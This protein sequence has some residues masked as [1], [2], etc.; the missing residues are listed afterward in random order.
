MIDTIQKKLPHIEQQHQ[1]TLLYVAE[2][3]SRAW[4]VASTD[5]DYD[6]RG[7]FIYP[8]QNYLAIDPPKETFEW[9]ENQWF[10]V[11][12]WELTKALRLLR[13]SNSVLLEWL[14]SPIVYRA[15]ANIQVELLNLAE[16][17]YQPRAVLYH[18]RGI[19][20]TASESMQGETIKLKKWFYLLRALL[21]A[22]WAATQ[23]TIPPMQL[24]QLL[25][26]LS[27]Q[28]Q[29]SILELVEFKADKDEHFLW[30]PPTPMKQLIERLWQTSDQSLATRDT[31][32]TE[33]L[34]TWFRKKLD[35][36]NP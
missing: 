25:A 19:A 33:M 31:P 12:G 15:Q 7:I 14:Q 20:K 28:E 6:V 23:Y 24:K 35:E 5:S 1:L 3:G 4:G 16:H 2:S 34:N 18:Y 22:Q 13:K 29:N 30:M 17:F 11:G 10:D 8:R 9:I 32:D 27:S 36:I 26:P 21:A